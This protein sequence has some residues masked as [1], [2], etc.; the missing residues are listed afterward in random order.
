MHG[1]ASHSVTSLLFPTE[2][3]AKIGSNVP[4]NEVLAVFDADQECKPTFFM[5]TLPLLDAGRDMAM[6]LTP[7]TF[8]NA[9]PD[10]DILNHLNVPFWHYTQ[11]GL[12]THCVIVNVYSTIHA[13]HQVGYDAL[14]IISCTGTNFLVRARAFMQAGQFPTQTLT[15][16]FALGI[17]LKA[18]GWK[19]KYV[20]EY[21]AVGEAP[22]DLRNAFQQRSRWAKGHFQ[23]FFSR[24]CPLLE[25]RVLQR[26]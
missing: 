15:E 21:L 12:Y 24:Y 4:F 1:V 14:N 17:R 25:V 16:D 6:V 2:E 19:C 22:D 11:V 20:E 8:Y 10:A 18:S 23:L 9:K 26:R 13:S 7:Q 5:R 3:S